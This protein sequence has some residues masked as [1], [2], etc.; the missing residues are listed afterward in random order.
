MSRHFLF[1]SILSVE[2][3]DL[4]WA[5]PTG[6]DMVI[7]VQ[8]LHGDCTLDLMETNMS[9]TPGRLLGVMVEDWEIHPMVPVP[10]LGHS[11]HSALSDFH[12]SGGSEGEA[13]GSLWTRCSGMASKSS[14]IIVSEMYAMKDPNMQRF[15]REVMGAG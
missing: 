15:G 1:S 9:L 6:Q 14:D 3:L 5:C 12:Y 2:C 4:C 8:M 13:V 10:C 11:W 7:I